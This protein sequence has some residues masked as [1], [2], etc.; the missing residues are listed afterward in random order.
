MVPL[1]TAPG[2]CGESAP[3]PVTCSP[4]ISGLTPDGWHWAPVALWPTWSGWGCGNEH[5]QYLDPLAGHV[6]PASR[7]AP[8]DGD[9]APRA[10]RPHLRAVRFL[11]HLRAL[12]ASTG[13]LRQRLGWV[14][15]RN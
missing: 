2:R 11:A 6:H 10:R 4:E 13:T 9:S 15:V 8:A 12:V 1:T 7:R 3:E 5:L 14:P